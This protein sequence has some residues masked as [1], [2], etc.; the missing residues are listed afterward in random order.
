MARALNKPESFSIKTKQIPE[1][2]KNDVLH[3]ISSVQTNQ[4]FCG[5]IAALKYKNPFGS[6]PNAKRDKSAH[7]YVH[8]HMSAE[9]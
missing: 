4:T 5:W 6:W 8:A 1:K 7:G 2:C 3:N 9:I